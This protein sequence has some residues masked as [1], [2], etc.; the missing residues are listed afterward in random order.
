VAVKSDI[1]L[2]LFLE[3]IRIFERKYLRTCLRK[4]RSQE[5][6][7]QKYLSNN[8]IYDLADKDL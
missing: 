4:Y 2:M 5:S 3:Q 8:K 1:I 6:N 7:Y